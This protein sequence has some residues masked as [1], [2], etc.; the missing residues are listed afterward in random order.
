MRNVEQTERF[1]DA[2]RAICRDHLLAPNLS[3]RPRYFHG[4]CLRAA[5]AL[6]G[7]RAVWLTGRALERWT[8]LGRAG[9]ID[10]DARN[11]S[12]RRRD[13]PCRTGSCDSSL[14][15]VRATSTGTPA[16]ARGSNSMGRA[17]YSAQWHGA[18]PWQTRTGVSQSLP[19][20]TIPTH[21]R[22][23]LVAQLTGALDVPSDRALAAGGDRVRRDTGPCRRIWKRDVL[24]ED[25]APAACRVGDR[26]QRLASV[27]STLHG[28]R[29]SGSTTCPSE[30]SRLY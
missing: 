14:A 8:R 17:G 18:R 1:K 4:A 13:G 9:L 26:R 6:S 28:A 12:R 19:P 27:I 25:Y 29:V 22:H 15:D 7:K 16:P 2:A 30:S 3:R 21:C 10:A 23:R 11:R 5:P 20:S 24:A